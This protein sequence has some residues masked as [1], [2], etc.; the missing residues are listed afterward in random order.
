[1][2]MA[3]GA[4]MWQAEPRV[5]ILLDVVTTPAVRRAQATARRDVRTS[6]ATKGITSRAVL[7][8]WLAAAVEHVLI[9]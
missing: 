9:A 2:R 6:H 7:L 5:L 1:M 4:A 3:H 8:M